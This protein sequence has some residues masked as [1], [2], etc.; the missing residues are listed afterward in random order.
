MTIYVA[1]DGSISL[2]QGDSGNITFKGLPQD[3]NYS[4]HF[5]FYDPEYN[6]IVGEDLVLNA[7]YNSEVSFPISAS[8]T[9]NLKVLSGE[10]CR[11]YNYGLKICSGEDEYTLIPKVEIVDG[12]PVF[13]SAPLV[14][15]YPKYVEGN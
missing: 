2:Y 6:Q 4:V 5:A 14:Y 12:K 11:I 13:Q 1:N 9:D 15:V 10:S 7:E 8:F 3:K